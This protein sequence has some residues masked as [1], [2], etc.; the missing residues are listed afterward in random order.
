MELCILAFGFALIVGIPVGMI[1][2]ITR[3]KW[4]DNLINAIALL[5]FSIPVFWLA[6]LLTLFCSLTLGW[7]PVSGRF[8]LLYEVKPITGFALIDARLSDSP[9]RDEMVMSAIRH[10]ILPVIT[11]SVA[12]T[13]EV[14]RLMRISTIEVYDQNYVKQ[15]R[16]AV[17]RALLFCVATFCITRYLRLFLARAY[18]FLPC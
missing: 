14:I 15:R 17:C 10:M 4:Q 8:D 1:A 5:G 16:P 11:L 7:L 6:L 9:W 18:S 2:G 13:T 3:H 12:P